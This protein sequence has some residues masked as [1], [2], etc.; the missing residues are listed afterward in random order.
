MAGPPVPSSSGGVK[1]FIS[2]SSNCL[3][4]KPGCLAISSTMAGQR[5]R[6]ARRSSV[7]EV[8]VA[9]DDSE[10]V[11]GASG[12][13]VDVS[14]DADV[15]SV[16]TADDSV[17]G[18][19]LRPASTDGAGLEVAGPEAAGPDGEGPDGLL[20][21]QIV[22]RPS[23]VWG[24]IVDRP[25]EVWGQI[26]DRPSEGTEFWKPLSRKSLSRKP[27]YLLHRPRLPVRCAGP[28]R[29]AGP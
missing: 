6:A 14:V 28:F 15:D 13:T 29:T 2:T 23:E 5:S 26:V 7:G 1:R 17:D 21:S 4:R 12:A 9:V 18:A 8:G 16:G 20:W 22:D 3:P 27:L 10:D 11:A 24:Q 19:G 25:S